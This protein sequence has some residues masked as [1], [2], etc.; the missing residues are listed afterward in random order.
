M[1][2]GLVALLNEQSCAPFALKALHELVDQYWSELADHLPN[3][4]KMYLT[5]KVDDLALL[6]SK[7]YFYLDVQ[8]LSLQYALKSD[9]D[10]QS[11]FV[12]SI[13]QNAIETFVQN[14]KD[15]KTIDP[16]LNE[17]VEK[18]IVDAFNNKD[19]DLVVGMAVQ[20]LNLPLIKR[21]ITQGDGVLNV[22]F[23][24]LFDAPSHF[25]TTVLEFIVSEF[26]NSKDYFSAVQCYLFLEEPLEISKLLVHLVENKSLLLAYQIAFDLEQE[27]SQFILNEIIKSLSL[28]TNMSIESPFANLQS[29]LSGKKSTLLYLEF[30]YRNNKGD[31]Q[32][33]KNINKSLDNRNSI[34]HTALSIA[35]AFMFSGTTYDQFLRDNL[36]WLSRATNW[37]KFTATAAL[38]VIHKGTSDSLK[39]L[40]PYLP[41]E[42]ISTQPHSEAGSLFALG[43]IHTKHATNDVT[44][45]ITKHLVSSNEILQHG[46]CLGLG[47]ALLASNNTAIYNQLRAILF[48][49][50]AIAGQAAA[51]AIG[52][53]MLG[54]NDGS[55]INEL[56]QYANDTQHET[57]IRGIS[58]GLSLL[59]YNQGNNADAVINE[60][61]NN[62]DPLLRYAGCLSLSTAYVNSNNLKAIKLL[63]HV[64]VSDVN[65]NV[66]RASCVALGFI[67]NDPNVITLL[68][69]SWNPHVRHG[70]CI[71]LGII[72]S[73]NDVV[74][75]N[76]WNSILQPLVK[77]SV[78]FVRQGALIALG[79]LNM[80]SNSA[81]YT[82][83][84]Q[85]FSKIISD[86][87]ESHMAKLGAI[88]GNGI[89]EAG[90]RNVVSRI[91][92]S[93]NNTLMSG[94]VGMLLYTQYWNWYPLSLFLSLTFV[95]TAI[96][97][98][99]KDL[100]VPK[101]T[102]KCSCKPSLY[103]YPL[104][105]E[106][107]DTKSEHVV[108][109]A[110]LSVV[111][112]QEHKR[113]SMTPTIDH[114][115]VATNLEGR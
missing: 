1:S 111:R 96:I 42:S 94:V 30:M 81:N 92:T 10:T 100:N 17:M 64:A 43:L 114:M 109:T 87:R 97:G 89:L 13:I 31:V 7:I 73:N 115:V 62:K 110:V 55:I 21:C 28:D 52:L 65:D 57:I 11:L 98:L 8:D 84:S 20:A 61:L 38:G 91:R 74:D 44:Q 15:N 83:T 39:I 102:L 63:L 85:I 9:L 16:L 70:S 35:N 80:Q 23:D 48:S 26:V 2:S 78:E 32:I 5:N 79:L 104:P 14:S 27:A 22:V 33:L 68:I 45:L 24:A 77:D 113:G 75:A 58:I 51:I 19:F 76:K 18:I 47:L 6:I 66:R 36:E 46:A 40:E 107:Q 72:C 90:G 93:N 95:P 112:K 86:K 101:M 4:E 103:K 49:D 67:S 12:K 37:S 69:N 56:I 108:K 71:A 82:R 25:R 106:L 105:L 54:S 3:L 59:M 41:Q 99:N 88:M 34:H 50:S 53:V 29:I 60:L